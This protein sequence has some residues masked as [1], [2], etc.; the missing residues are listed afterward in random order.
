[1]ITQRIAMTTVRV[2]NDCIG[3][4]TCAVDC[5]A[6]VFEIRREKSVPINEDD[7]IECLSCL[8]SCPVN[9]IS[10]NGMYEDEFES[11]DDD[12]ENGDEEELDT[13]EDDEEDELSQNSNNSFSWNDNMNNAIDL[14]NKGV[15]YNSRG[16]Y[17]LAIETYYKALRIAEKEGDARGVETIVSNMIV[18]Y[19]DKSLKYSKKEDFD[20]AID[21]LNEALAIAEN[22]WID[23]STDKIK[24]MLSTDYN[25]KAMALPEDEY[26]EIIENLDIAIGYSEAA[27]DK[28]GLN[29]IKSNLAITY[30]NFA[31]NLGNDGL[32]DQSIKYLLMALNI[33]K[34]IRDTK[35]IKITNSNLAITYYHYGMEHYKNGNS[36]KAIH[37]LEKS[38]DLLLLLNRAEDEDKRKFIRQKLT[39]LYNNART[40]KQ[41]SDQGQKKQ[42]HNY[43][44]K[45]ETPRC[46]D[47]IKDLLKEFELDPNGNITIKEIKSQY[48]Y[49]VEILHPDKNQNKSET[50]RKKAEEKLK[51]INGIYNKLKEH[52]TN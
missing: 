10:V 15:E 11:E 41:E 13:D 7:C 25:N 47:Y 20:Y 6:D 51:R 24:I 31:I 49:F 8:L 39:E 1:M 16:N 48:Y 33:Q 21:I 19:I 52:Y 46:P 30:S 50:A 34:D 45:K 37:N 28:K 27:G 17:D 14:N 18:S 40:K 26:L 29:E 2:D 12:D 4:G 42:K 22:Y 38:L 44:S 36:Q 35:G 32:H 9:A 3:C 5:P 43:E 23:N